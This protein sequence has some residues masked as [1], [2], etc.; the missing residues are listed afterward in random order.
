MPKNPL[1]LGLFWDEDKSV[2]DKTYAKIGGFL[3]G[4]KFNS[5]TF[6]IPPNVASRWLSSSRSPWRASARRSRTRATERDEFDRTRVGVILGN[7]MGGEV[8]DD[9][10]VRTRVP[11]FK[12]TLKSLPAF[13]ELDAAVQDQ[14][15]TGFE[16]GLKGDP[17]IINE[18]SMPGELSNVI[19]GRVANAFDLCGPNFTVDAACA[20]GGGYT[21]CRKVA[22]ERRY[23][24]VCHGWRGPLYGRPHL[25]QVL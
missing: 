18:D 11:A 8:T 16:D 19:A 4:F 10:V 12:E 24:H 20:S 7:S 14:I 1:G 15:L 23:R 9:Y 22:S 21:V 17:P 25:H 13:A 6:R 5:R 2:P 3:Q